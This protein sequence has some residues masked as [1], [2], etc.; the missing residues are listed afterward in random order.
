MKTRTPRAGWVAAVLLAV[1]AFPAWARAQYLETV[2]VPTSS[3]VVLRPSSYVDSYYPTTYLTSS[4]YVPTSYVLA[5]T[6]YVVPTAYYAPARY[7]VPTFLR[8]PLVTTAYTRALTSYYVPT[9]SYWPTTTTSYVRTALT[10]CCEPV[11]SDCATSVIE[12]PA[13]P[14]PAASSP[15]PATRPEEPE[16]QPPVRSTPRN[17]AGG[18]QAQ[19]PSVGADSEDS[20]VPPPAEAL[21]APPSDPVSPPPALP[22]TAP[23]ANATRAQPATATRQVLRPASYARS[24]LVGKVVSAVG[25]EPVKNLEIILVPA[26]DRFRSRALTTDEHGEFRAVLF[27]GDWTVQVPKAEGTAT[28]DVPVTVAGGLITDGHDQVVS[29]LTINR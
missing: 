22:A 10:D 8:R 29:V 5:P 15:A 4:Y 20:I 2:Y 25:G 17:G 26:S 24:T 3:T 21:G 27:E 13:A 1:L 19:P 18:V 23:Q 6:S 12:R 11:P 9:V 16:L 7:V 14:R 28:M